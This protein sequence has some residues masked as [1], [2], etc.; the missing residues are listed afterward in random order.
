MRALMEASAFMGQD[1]AD[2]REF[3]CWM[4]E[5]QHRVFQIAYSVLRNAADAEEIA[6]E[7]FVQAHRKLSSLRE[8]SKFR[9]W[10]GRIAFRLALNHQRAGR[11]RLERDRAWHDASLVGNNTSSGVEG[12]AERRMNERIFLQRLAAAVDSLPEKLRSSLLLSAV[13]G[14]TSEEAAEILDVPAGTVRSRLHQARRELLR[15]MQP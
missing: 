15:R 1:Q 4:A 2:D 11:R 13:E 7:A 3:A 5:S 8:Q 10:V 14:F 12:D 6:Q 9:L